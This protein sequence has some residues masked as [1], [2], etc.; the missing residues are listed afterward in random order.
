MLQEYFRTPSKSPFEWAEVKKTGN[1]SRLLSSFISGNIAL[2]MVRPLP[3]NPQRPHPSED[4][5]ASLNLSS[6]HISASKCMHP[7]CA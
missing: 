5:E 4:G 7:D 2:Q 3:Q 6:L 1:K